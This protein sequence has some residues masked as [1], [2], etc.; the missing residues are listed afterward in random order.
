M[1][2][3]GLLALGSNMSSEFGTPNE[4]IARAIM[5]LN[6]NGIQLRA[7]SRF[8]KTPCFPAGAG[9]D[10]I[11]AALAIRTNL[12]PETLLDR[13]HTIELSFGRERII[14]W[15][16]RPVDIDLISLDNIVLPNLETHAL[17]R[18]LPLEKQ[19]EVAPDQLILP[20]P[21]LQDRAFVL[22]P[23]R[24][25][26]MTSRHPILGLTVGEMFAQLP[27]TAQD[28]PKPL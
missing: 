26:A 15:G 10:Y 18:N 1:D 7:V 27:Q 25:I 14:R 9:P 11:N 21:R 4:T 20:H 13:L 19:K 16:A 12:M 23:L 2:S 3:F 17:W 28:E 22:G 24:D 6:S 5:Q 8:Y